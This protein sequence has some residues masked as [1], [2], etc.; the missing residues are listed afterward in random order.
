VKRIGKGRIGYFRQAQNVGSLRNFETCINRAKG[1]LVHI[2]HGDDKV[3][4]GYYAAMSRLFNA[5]P[6]AGAAFCRFNLIDEAGQVLSVKKPEALQDGILENWLERI[7]EKQR[8]QYA[9]ITVKREVYE[10]LG[11][12]YATTYGEDWE[13]WARI[14]RYYP[15][16]YTPEV[17]AD[18]RFRF[19]SITG[20][21]FMTGENLQD[22]TRTMARIQELLP[23]DKKKTVLQRS[24]KH[25]AN[26]GLLVA[27][28]LWDKRHDRTAVQA[29]IRQ[30][31][32]IYRSPLLYLKITRLYLKMLFSSL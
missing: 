13:M 29:Q 11:A 6:E 2:L 1:R 4:Y 26:Y 27:G 12:F 3:R 8:I 30:A 32:S 21:K 22:L 28:Q 18:Y 5:Y 23:P 7:G 24:R 19:A 9:A 10:M 15:V 17:L 31:R 25:Y 14:A 16:A 20:T